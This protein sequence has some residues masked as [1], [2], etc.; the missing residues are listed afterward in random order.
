MRHCSHCSEA[1]RKSALPAC[2]TRFCFI[3]VPQVIKT[4]HGVL[5]LRVSL[6]FKV[7]ALGLA[8]REG[9]IGSNFG[10]LGEAELVA[11]LAEKHERQHENTDPQG[12]HGNDQ[13]P[14]LIFVDDCRSR[15]RRWIAQ[16]DLRFHQRALRFHQLQHAIRALVARVVLWG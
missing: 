7:L 9:G 10:L 13:V 1:S 12:K 6:L 4:V 14:I 11:L 8:L 5:L 3:H 16:R 2:C 15:L